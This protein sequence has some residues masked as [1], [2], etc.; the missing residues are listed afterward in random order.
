MLTLTVSFWR[1]PACAQALLTVTDDGSRAFFSVSGLRPKGLNQILTGTQ[2]YSF[3]AS[4]LQ[5]AL[6]SFP[7]P[8]VSLTSIAIDGNASVIAANGV[9]PCPPGGPFTSPPCSVGFEKYQ[10][11]IRL[12]SGSLT[13]AGKTAFSSNGRYAVI[14]GQSGADPK[15]VVVMDLITGVRFVTDDLSAATGR[16]LTAAGSVVVAKGDRLA[17]VSPAS[18]RSFGS[19]PGPAD[20]LWVDDSGSTIVYELARK[21]HIRDADGHDL[22]VA[23]DGADSFGPSLSRDGQEISFLSI[24]DGVPQVFVS[25]R[26]GSAQQLTFEP[27]GIGEAVITGDGLTVFMLTKTGR[28]LKVPVQNPVI[29]RLLGPAFNVWRVGPLTPGSAVTVMG[30]LSVGSLQVSVNGVPAPVFSVTSDSALFQAPWEIANGGSPPSVAGANASVVITFDNSPWEQASS[31]DWE[32]FSP[33]LL[34]QNM[35]HQ[36]FVSLVTQQHP[37]TP[38][39]TVHLFGTGLGPVDQPVQT[40]VPSPPSPLARITAG[41]Q[42]VDALH[43]DRP[44]EVLFAGLAPNL[45]GQYQIDLRLPATTAGPP[46]VGL[47]CRLAGHTLQVAVIATASVIEG[48]SAT[49]TAGRLRKSRH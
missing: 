35:A 45:I 38:G 6:T 30:T 21:V 34:P 36:D 1:A 2:G 14:F 44:L 39:E 49:P 43:D 40:G 27:E 28:L 8:E 33:T 16:F 47:A 24:V 3:S 37:G 22:V 10:T 9:R 23:P 46:A 11:V 13:F 5:S 4:G 15:S 31:S 7:D 17:L 12:S 29:N 32:P 20:S 25:T 18:E 48:M 41:C 42:W 19:W 26:A